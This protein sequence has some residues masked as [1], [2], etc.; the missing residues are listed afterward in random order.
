MRVQAESLRS[1]AQQMTASAV[2]ERVRSMGKQE[3]DGR[4][5]AQ[6]KRSIVQEFAAFASSRSPKFAGASDE[7]KTTTASTLLRANMIDSSST[8]YAATR[9]IWD[10]PGIGREQRND[11]IMAELGVSNLWDAIVKV[12]EYTGMSLIE[13][14]PQNDYEAYK[15][16]ARIGFAYF[17][18]QKK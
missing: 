7:E 11:A 14:K 9:P 8:F 6:A 5:A 3:L 2:N 13:M 12:E 17:A 15:M 10:K 1:Q 16:K 18:N 4:S